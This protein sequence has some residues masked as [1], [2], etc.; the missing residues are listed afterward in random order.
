MLQTHRMP[1][2]QSQPED[3]RNSEI[4]FREFFSFPHKDAPLAQDQLSPF[5]AEFPQPAMPGKSRDASRISWSVAANIIFA[6][7][8]LAGGL[9]SSFHF[10]NSADPPRVISV[11]P[12]RFV[13]ERPFVL[14]SDPTIEKFDSVS[15]Q[16]RQERAFDSSN[17]HEEGVNLTSLQPHLKPA[18]PEKRS[19]FLPTANFTPNLSPARISQTSRG[20]ASSAASNRGP[21]SA[22]STKTGEAKTTAKLSQAK[23][24]RAPKN[25]GVRL[26]GPAQHAQLKIMK[27]NR[28]GQDRPHFAQFDRARP[29]MDSMKSTRDFGS[30]TTA[31][32]SGRTLNSGS[33]FRMSPNLSR[34]SR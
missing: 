30:R 5:A 22:S 9:F 20:A 4:D 32:S 23:N 29:A 16:P 1:V 34:G 14:M 11:F 33:S 10:F 25:S 3:H 15:I 17:R 31:I 13:Y 28:T 2:D 12:P 21:T 7:I 24:H 6:A 27:L 19:V 8:A 26:K 18:R